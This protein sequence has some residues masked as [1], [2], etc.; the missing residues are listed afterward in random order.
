MHYYSTPGIGTIK[1]HMEES[2]T[3]EYS[4][5][6]HHFYTKAKSAPFQANLSPSAATLSFPVNA[7]RV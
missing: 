6:T 7:L 1:K 4:L 3:P 2:K 5:S